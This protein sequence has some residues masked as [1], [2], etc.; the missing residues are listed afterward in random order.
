[1]KVLVILKLSVET[2]VDL[3]EFGH[4]ESQRWDNLTEEQQNEI[5]DPMRENQIPDV[6]V[7]IIDED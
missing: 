6:S 3:T 1:M 4:D 5:L 2:E 7:E